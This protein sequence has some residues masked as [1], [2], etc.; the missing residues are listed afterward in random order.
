MT[1]SNPLA[2][3][4]SKFMAK[5]LGKYSISIHEDAYKVDLAVVDR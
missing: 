2:L 5:P 1:F 4:E 3:F